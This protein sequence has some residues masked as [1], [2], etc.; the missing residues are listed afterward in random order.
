MLW[1]K[2]KYTIKIKGGIARFNTEKMRGLAAHIII[3]P[4]GTEISYRV[5]MLDKDGDAV[6]DRYCCGRVDD[7]EGLPIGKDSQEKLTVIFTKVSANVEFD[8]IFKI[9]EQ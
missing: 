5:Q 1:D 9:R 6:Y 3:I 8:I 2:K 4:N 7:K